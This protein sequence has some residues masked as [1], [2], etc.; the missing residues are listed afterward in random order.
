LTSFHGDKGM[1]SK[2]VIHVV[3]LALL[4]PTSLLRS[5]TTET[6]IDQASRHSAAVL[7][8]SDDPCPDD[9]DIYTSLNV[10]S[11]V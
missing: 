3:A 1:V 5:Q 9:S 11:A 6:Y 4:L 8:R 10:W 2:R 7:E